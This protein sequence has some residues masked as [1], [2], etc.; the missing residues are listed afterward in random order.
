[1]KHSIILLTGLVLLAVLISGCT[2]QPSAAPATA[3][4]APQQAAATAAPA[5]APQTFVGS[6]WKLGWFDDT[7]GMWSKIAEGSS[8][9]ATFTADGKLTGFSGCSDYSTTYEF[10]KSPLIFI[11]RPAVSTKTCQT[12]V[13]V[14]SQESAYF[15]DLEWSDSYGIQNGQLLFFNKDGRKILQFDPA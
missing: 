10:G 7:K 9:T 5:P 1:M 14:M 13:G 4:P 2:S 15:T 6:E 3:T 11:K 12:P 8:I